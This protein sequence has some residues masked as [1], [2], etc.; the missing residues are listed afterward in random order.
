MAPQLIGELARAAGVNPKTIRYYEEIGLLPPPRRAENT[1][2]LYGGEDVERLAFI[3]RARALDLN[4]EEIAEILSF[5]DQ[6]EAPCPYVLGLMADKIDEIQTKIEGLRR[7]K[8][9]LADLRSAAARVP[10]EELAA[11]GQVCHIIE[12]QTLIRPSEI[13]A[14]L[15]KTP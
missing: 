14:S 13:L 9:E 1:Y 15:P 6:G 7:L 12:N 4:L 11:K 3:R 10:A 2:R 5:R 8:G